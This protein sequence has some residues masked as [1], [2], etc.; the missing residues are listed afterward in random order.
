M[1][2]IVIVANRNLSIELQECIIS[3]LGKQKALIAIPVEDDHD[4]QTKQQEI[5]DAICAVD[6]GNGVAIVTDI[7]GSSPANLSLCACSGSNSVVLTGANLPMLI[8]LVKS[9]RKNLAEATGLAFQAGKNHIMML[10]E[11]ASV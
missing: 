4:R 5:C 9:R 3:I 7:F 10:T 1:I 11:K 8:K 6:D 2:G